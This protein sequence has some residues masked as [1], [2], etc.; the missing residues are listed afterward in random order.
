MFTFSIQISGLL[1][2]LN[3]FAGPVF[4]AFSLPLLLF[5]PQ[6][7]NRLLGTGNKNGQQ[8]SKGEFDWIEAPELL[9]TRMF[10]LIVMYQMLNGVKVVLYFPFENGF[11]SLFLSQSWH[12]C[13]EKNF[14]AHSRSLS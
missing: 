2:L 10:R 1:I 12:T 14:L 7:P 13:C 8:S 4:F 5:W 3:T 9:R 6:I 11:Q